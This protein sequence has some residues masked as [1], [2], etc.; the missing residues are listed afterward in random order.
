M[1]WLSS[2]YRE[3]EFKKGRYT[4]IVCKTYGLFDIEVEVKENGNHIISNFFDEFENGIDFALNFL[5]TYK[6]KD[7]IRVSINKDEYLV[8]IETI[9]DFI[10][11]LENSNKNTVLGFVNYYNNNRIY[12][13]AFN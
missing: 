7:L 5:R 1:G 12:Y 11:K 10:N 6:D 4:A 9:E 13:N 2:N 8:E 3:K